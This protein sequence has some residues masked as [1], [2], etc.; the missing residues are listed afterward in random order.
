MSRC[1]TRRFL[2]VFTEF[3][4]MLGN[5]NL[6]EIHAFKER[7]LNINFYMFLIYTYAFQAISSVQIF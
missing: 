7:F 5:G 3:C 1:K 6:N 4:L 2:A